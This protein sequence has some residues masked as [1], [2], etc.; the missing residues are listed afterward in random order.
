MSGHSVIGFFAS[1][2]L[3]LNA[4]KSAQAQRCGE[5]RTISPVPL[6][7]ISELLGEKPSPVRR[8]TLAGGLLGLT[9][10][11]LLPIGSVYHYPLIVGGKPLVSLTPFAVVAYICTILFGALFTVLGMLLNARLPR[12]Q[13]GRGYD[14]RLTGNRFGLQV[15]CAQ[16]EVQEIERKMLDF[17]AE[18]VKYVEV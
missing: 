9:V 16:R 7:E 6:P 12:I 13:V 8:F 15:I 17:G 10:G 14:P 5:I 11:W 4:V 1:Y 18:E 2:D 3:L